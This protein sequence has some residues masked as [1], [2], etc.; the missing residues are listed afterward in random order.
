VVKTTAELEAVVTVVCANQRQMPRRDPLR[1]LMEQI[2]QFAEAESPVKPSQVGADRGVAPGTGVKPEGRPRIGAAAAGQACRKA[3]GP[4]LTADAPP[5]PRAPPSPLAPRPRQMANRH[6]DIE[7]LA[8]DD[9]EYN[10]DVQGLAALRRRLTGAIHNYKGAHAQYE[11]A[12]R[13][14]LGLQEVVKARERGA[15]EAPPGAPGAGGCFGRVLVDLGWAQAADG[16]GC[17]SGSRPFCD[18]A[19]PARPRAHASR[20]N[21]PAGKPWGAALWQYRC[22]VHPY[23]RKV[24]GSGANS[25]GQGPDRGWDAEDW[26]L[27]ALLPPLFHARDTFCARPPLPPQVLG[28]LLGCLSVV[29][30][31]SEATIIT[32]RKPDLSPFSLAIRWAGVA[33]GAEE[34]A[35]G[36]CTLGGARAAP[37]A[38]ADLRRPVPRLPPLHP[39]TRCPTSSACSF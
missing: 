12:V 15:Y 10:Y 33:R 17:P 13:A 9:L 5:A 8:A 38:A 7:R 32:G 36:S 31:W 39:G 11:E 25:R 23:V 3:A 24:R 2:A 30:V 21:H 1:P 34:L 29:I 20:C 18:A 26:L 19:A 4:R 14:G 35:L 37:G 22:V 28:V 16:R 27:R 6:L